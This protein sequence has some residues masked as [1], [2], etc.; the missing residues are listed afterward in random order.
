MNPERIQQID[1]WA[2]YVK[3]SRG[4]WKKEHTAFI[5]AQFEKSEAFYRRLAQT[6]GGKQKINNLFGIKNLNAVP[7][8]KS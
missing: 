4:A 2:Q 7:F 5:N 1:R 3:K 8:L 6:P